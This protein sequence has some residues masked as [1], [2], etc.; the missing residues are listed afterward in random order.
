MAKKIRYLC[1][2]IIILLGIMLVF[3]YIYKSKNPDEDNIILI[4]G[5]DTRLYYMYGTVLGID[6]NLGTLQVELETDSDL[7][8]FFNEQG[9]FNLNDQ[10]FSKKEVVLEYSNN[11]ISEMDLKEGDYISFAFFLFDIKDDSVKI[12]EINF[13]AAGCEEA[14]PWV[15][16]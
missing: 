13:P 11:K 9:L 8:N 12:E 10:F 15:I 16:D 7:C 4:G 14:D 6:S 2:Y 5:I 1:I 3:K